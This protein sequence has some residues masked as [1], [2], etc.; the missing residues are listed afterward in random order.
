[1]NCLFFYSKYRK[2]NF[3]IC[4]QVKLCVR[5]NCKRLC[6][7]YY[8]NSGPTSG[9]NPR[10]WDGECHALPT[11]LAGLYDV[12]DETVFANDH[13]F[14]EFF[15]WFNFSV[16]WNIDV[17]KTFFFSFAFELYVKWICKILFFE[18]YEKFSPIMRLEPTT[19]GVRIPCSTDWASRAVWN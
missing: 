3:F 14:S 8:K 11:E 13:P 19:L 18:Y 4:G 5:W 2:S 1:M 16:I 10:P 9:S 12:N 15:G 17:L 6:F 7:D